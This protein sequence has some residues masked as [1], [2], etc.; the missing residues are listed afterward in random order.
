MRALGFVLLGHAV[1]RVEAQ[2]VYVA[3]VSV[4]HDRAVI[5]V[6]FRM[7]ERLVLSA[8]TLLSDGTFLETEGGDLSRSLSMNHAV[9]PPPAS[10]FRWLLLRDAGV[11]EVVE[12]HR[13]H[14]AR[15]VAERGASPVEH[16]MTTHLA[17]RLRAREIADAR[18][19]LRLR[20]EDRAISAMALITWLLGIAVAL[21]F[22]LLAGFVAWLATIAVSPFVVQFVGWSLSPVLHRRGRW[23]RLSVDTMRERAASVPFGDVD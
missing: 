12:Q 7:G 14:L 9:R 22:G 5:L 4:H 13:A 10:G 18:D 3:E 11:A 16:D 6:A 20:T 15:A 2:A 21:R 23:S 8:S 19:A 1:A 17:M